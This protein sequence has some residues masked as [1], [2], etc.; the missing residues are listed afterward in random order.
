[1]SARSPAGAG[2]RR[3]RGR[4]LDGIVALW[5]ALTEHHAEVDSLFALRVGA[6][7]E[8]RR[9]IEA[10]LRDPDT[11]VFVQGGS[12]GTA[13]ARDGTD[14]TLSG[15]CIARVDRAPPIHLETCRGEITDLFVRVSERRR[16]V[17]RALLSAALDWV[18][19]RGASRVEVRVAATNPE[20]LAFW[21]ASGF[22]DF[23]DVLHRPL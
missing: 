13:R 12:D 23:M 16:G 15:L 11:A 9:L 2:V 4:D 7:A 19:Q 5:I 22:A 17:G 20:G 3:A 21:R 10:Q 18:R 8:V 1:M 6:E 14:E